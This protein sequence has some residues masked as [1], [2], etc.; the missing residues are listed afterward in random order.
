MFYHNG[1]KWIWLNAHAPRGRLVIEREDRVVFADERFAAAR[2]REGRTDGGDEE[3]APKRVLGSDASLFLSSM[4][5]SVLAFRARM[6]AT[7]RSART[8]RTRGM[9]AGSSWALES[10]CGTMPLMI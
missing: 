4:G 7:S 8:E 5:R 1:Y 9:C 10:H 3:E 6:R 2:E